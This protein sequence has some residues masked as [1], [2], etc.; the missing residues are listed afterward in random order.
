MAAVGSDKA[1]A[2]RRRCVSSSLTP[3][4]PTDAA[5]GVLAIARLSPY[6]LLAETPYETRIKPHRG[7]TMS[8]ERVIVE[9]HDGTELSYLLEVFE[10]AGHWTS[11][12]SRLDE[13]NE[14]IGDRV[15]PRFYGMTA[16]Q[17]RRGTLKVLENQYDEV[18]TEVI[19]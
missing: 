11:T 19:E 13:N 4:R 2:S 10:E 14:P 3:T 8:K 12:L 5:Q 9:T 6:P 15:A 17:A 16:E 1:F 18:R 7:K